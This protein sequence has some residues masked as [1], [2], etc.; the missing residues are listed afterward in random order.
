MTGIGDDDRN[1][2]R[3]DRRI[4]LQRRSFLT[5]VGAT[6]ALGARAAEPGRPAA[7]FAPATLKS[8]ERI[9]TDTADA[10]Y[11]RHKVAATKPWIRRDVDVYRITYATRD[12]DGAEVV[13]SGAVLVPKG[14]EAAPLMAYG[15]GT[16]VP[17]TGEENAPSYYRREKIQ[18]VYGD[19]YEMSYLAATFASAGYVVA[20]PD[21]IGYGASKGREHPYIHAASLAWTS[22]D[23]LRATREF[24][25]SGPVR[26]DGRLFITGWSEGGLCGMALHHL[27]ESTCP[28]EFPV[29]A[30]SLLAGTYAISAQIHLFCSYE[31]DYP[32][33][34]INY[35]K[36]R[37]ACRVYKLPRPFDRTVRPDYARMLEKDVLAPVPKDPRAGL[38]PDFRARFL[39]G[40]EP[41]ME[42]ALRDSDRYDWGPRAPVFLHHGTRDDIVPFFCAQMAFE[43]MRRRGARV[44]LR[45]YLGQDHY[46]PAEPYVP[47]TLADFDAIR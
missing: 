13:A 19:H 39:D 24:L 27:I 17:V 29:T 26:H 45:P 31:E 41:E 35:W 21:A 5:A 9:A 34:A 33:C 44:A 4:A 43:A 46:R 2:D 11:G 12:T 42:A 23:M 3:P 22:L 36:L 16:I 6:T 7:G 38:D 14:V 32:E 8:A 10:I 28:D 40:R 1:A 20:A 30:S 25:A 37:T 47:R 18:D 15:R